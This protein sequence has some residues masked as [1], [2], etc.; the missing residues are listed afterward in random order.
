MKKLE[1]QARELENYVISCRRQ[2][3]RYAELGGRE[4]QTGAFI[5]AEAEK[6]GLEVERVGQTGRLVILDTGR[7]G[8]GVALRADMDALPLK[9]NPCNCKRNRVVVSD[10]PDTCHA[11]GHDAHVAMLL[12]AMQILAQRR[13]EWRGRVYFC[14]ESDEESGTGWQDMVEA[15]EKRQVHTVFALHVLSSL[16]S[17]LISV[18]DG[19]RMSGMVRVDATFVGRGGHGSRPDLSIN[20]VFAAAAAL[21]NLAIAAANQVDAN[22]TVTLGIT[23]IRG[24]EA[25]NVI[26]D[27]AQVLGTM[28]YFNLREGEK[29]LQMLK[30]VFD[31]TA[32]M[33][34]C[35]VEYS[36]LTCNY[37]I[38]TI[39]DPEAASM[40]REAL[41]RELG[42]EYV[43]SADKWYAS[44]SFSEYL[45]RYKGAMGFLGV[46]NE[47]LGTTAEHH[48]E[49]FDVDESVLYR[50][51]MSYAGYAIEAL[52]SEKVAQ[53]KPKSE[54]SL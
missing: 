13:E 53:W 2:V 43:V 26:P 20:P 24:G 42:E 18:D 3:H 39:N 14:F 35:M 12:G 7:P 11:C 10:A 31:H 48:N 6:L 40:A 46:R 27:R 25:Y 15:L 50:G 28:R 36:P 49:H 9:E 32:Q 21:N 38:P 17:G 51:V 30:S 33:H 37:I 34:R 1:Q 52:C 8:N 41:C 45:R 23:S 5:E 54:K 44:E 29:A 47:E 16:E 4:Y 19:P 22:E